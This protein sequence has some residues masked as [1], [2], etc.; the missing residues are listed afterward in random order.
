M[1][2]SRFGGT[3]CPNA[4]K[5]VNF[6]GLCCFKNPRPVYTWISA[7]KETKQKKKKETKLAS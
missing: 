3:Q 6:A 5:A 1:S 4:E 7:A 2:P